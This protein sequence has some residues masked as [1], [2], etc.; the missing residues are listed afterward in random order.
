[1]SSSARQTAPHDVLLGTRP[2]LYAC[3][4]ASFGAEAV[5]TGDAALRYEKEADCEVV[6]EFIDRAEP[7]VD[8][9]GC[10]GWRR[11]LAVVEAGTADGI[12]TPLM[13]MLGRGKAEHLADWQQRTGAYLMTSSAIDTPKANGLLKQ[14]AA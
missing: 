10:P 5:N 3:L 4:P 13:V 6:A 8:R 7:I 14:G 12:L 1:M 11:A 2:V 9:D